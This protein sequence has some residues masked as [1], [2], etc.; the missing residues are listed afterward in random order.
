MNCVC[1]W[2]GGVYGVFVC[3]EVR[4]VCCVHVCLCYVGVHGVLCAGGACCVLR[5]YGGVY[6]VFV[7]VEVRVS[8]CVLCC[9]CM[10]VCTGY[11][12]LAGVG[13]SV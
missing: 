6:G 4:V 9:V 11:F 5:E 8:G 12:V 2:Y 1:V 10:G 3:V 7:G 13:G